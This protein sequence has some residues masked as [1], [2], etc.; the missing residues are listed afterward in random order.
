MTRTTGQ[1][2]GEAAAAGGGR[3][4]LTAVA[5]AWVLIPFI[6]GVIMLVLKLPALF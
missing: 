6:Y 5:W 2:P 1:A 3:T 4:A